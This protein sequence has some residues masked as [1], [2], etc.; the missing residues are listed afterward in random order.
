M[1]NH[2]MTFRGFPKQDFYP[3]GIKSS[4]TVDTIQ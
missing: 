1:T 2:S 3:D 4:G